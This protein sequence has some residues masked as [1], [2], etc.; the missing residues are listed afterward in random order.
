MKRFAVLFVFAGLFLS[1]R[2]GNNITFSGFENRATECNGVKP[3]QD[4]LITDSSVFYAVTEHLVVKYIDDQGFV[5]FNKKGERL[6]LIYPFDNGPDY[7]SEGLFR[8]I[9]EDEIGFA[10]MKG[11][12]V[13]QP[14][15]FAVLPFHDGRAAFCEG[16]RKVQYGEH[17]AREG[18]QWGFIDSKGN[19]A[20]P[21][22]YEKVISGFSNGM[23]TVVLNGRQITID[24]SGNILKP[25]TMEDPQW[26]TLL[27]E[28]IKLGMMSSLH[29]SPEII[30]SRV[31]MMPRFGELRHEAMK[32]EVFYKNG[33]E[34]LMTFY[35][36]PWQ[37]L[38]E[39]INTGSPDE[40]INSLLL[41][42][43]TGYAMI[44]AM[45]SLPELT[46]RQEAE[47]LHFHEI[48]KTLINYDENQESTGEL[49][50]LPEDIRVISI[51]NYRS[52]VSMEIALP[53]SHLPADWSSLS[54]NKMLRIE[55]FPDRGPITL[56]WQKPSATVTDTLLREQEARLIGIFDETLKKSMQDNE[57]REVLFKEAEKKIRNVLKGTERQDNT[58]FYISRLKR[59][60]F[61]ETGS[62]N[63]T[64]EI[65]N[66]P[67]YTPKLT[68]DVATDY[69]PEI[70]EIISDLPASSPG[71][72]M[73]L[74][75]LFRIY[76]QKAKDNPGEWVEGNMILGAREREYRP[77]SDELI[78]AEI[79]NR[80]QTVMKILPDREIHK[81]LKKLKIK[82]GDLEYNRFSFIHLDVM[83]SGRFFYVDK[84]ERISLPVK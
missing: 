32:T 48:F 26:I 34:P 31:K 61:P 78:L 36:L 27:R 55:I 47:I 25:I 58:D 51:S 33:K 3:F 59:W 66:F 60:L 12:V 20:I 9:E 52:Y 23:A 11:E 15:F 46:P 38:T 67:D 39:Q 17:E 70:A 24:T 73:K 8:I 18:G 62:A 69:M 80:L 7:P 42:T 74:L 79:G 76:S 5:A 75:E 83:G 29:D 22:V 50:E 19:V 14:R 41:V 65:E 72:F 2:P 4:T 37:N 44:F 64:G 16:C 13:I 84:I 10:N 56:I 77:T 82:P 40:E 71:N 53:G 54:E 35:F 6:C 1:T 28:A 30:N 45:D 81:A 21:P 49:P 57:N 63:P 43:V 68:P